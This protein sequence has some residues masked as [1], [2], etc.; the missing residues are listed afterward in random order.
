MVKLLTERV[1]EIIFNIFISKKLKSQSCGELATVLIDF[2]LAVI[3]PQNYF[4]AYSVPIPLNIPN[5]FLIFS[6]LCSSPKHTINLQ[7]FPSNFLHILPVLE[8]LNFLRT[9]F[10]FILSTVNPKWR[11]K[12]FSSK[13]ISYE[14]LSVHCP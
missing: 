7:T 6:F 1:E 2:K 3:K 13:N 12:L 9:Y 8:L 11:W 4:F 5:T 14:A 10:T